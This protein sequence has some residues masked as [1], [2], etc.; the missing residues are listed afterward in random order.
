MAD[1]VGAAGLELGDQK[2]RQAPLLLLRE[3]AVMQALTG[4]CVIAHLTPLANSLG[5][6]SAVSQM[7]VGL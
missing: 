6:Q 7:M 4:G 3:L 2:E 5:V 1:S